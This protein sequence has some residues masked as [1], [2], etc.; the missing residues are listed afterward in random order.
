MRGFAVLAAVAV[1]FSP[2]L[3]SNPGEPLDCSDWVFL[4]PG[5]WCEPVVPFPCNP[6]L[7]DD[8]FC[9]AVE[10]G[11][12]EKILAGAQR[13]IITISVFKNVRAGGCQP[14]FNYTVKVC[15]LQRDKFH[16]GAGFING[17]ADPSDQ[18]SLDQHHALAGSARL[19]GESNFVTLSRFN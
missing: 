2:V 4:E 10:W 16:M 9:N 12:L 18:F 1:F 13:R 14:F 19:K 3:A 5:F 11:G 15:S 8:P 17:Q 7:E 6:N